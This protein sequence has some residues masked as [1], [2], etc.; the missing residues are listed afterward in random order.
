MASTGR[1]STGN[2]RAKRLHARRD[3][4]DPLRSDFILVLGSRL[5]IR[6]TRSGTVALEGDRPIFHVDCDPGEVNNR[7]LGCEPIVVD[8]KSFLNSRRADR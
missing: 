3:G 1:E 4:T 6:Q 8:L 5:D 2:A 7:V